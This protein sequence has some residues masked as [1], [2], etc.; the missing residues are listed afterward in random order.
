MTEFPPNSKTAK[1][2]SKEPKQLEKVASVNAKRRRKPLGSRFRETFV[3]GDAKSAGGYV[4]QTVVVPMIRDLMYE[5]AQ[6]LLQKM[7]FGETRNRQ[8][9]PSGMFGRV[10]YTQMTNP[11]RAGQ[12]AKTTS[13]QARARH[14]FDELVLDSRQG[15][16]EVIDRMMDVLSQWEVVTVADLYTLVGF[17]AAHTDYKWGWTDLRGASVSRTRNGGYLL[18]LPQPKAL[19]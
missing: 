15:A 1:A 10:D 16:E 7:I 5:A 12:Q 19:Q 14:S 17:E 13:S 4:V 3:Q 8:T 18:D 11:T 9:P 6:S 2:G